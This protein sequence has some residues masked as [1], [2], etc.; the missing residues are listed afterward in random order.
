[1]IKLPMDELRR[2]IQE[3]RYTKLIALEFPDE[4]RFKEAVRLGIAREVPF[5]VPGRHNLIMPPSFES[6]FENMNYKIWPVRSG[7]ELTSEERAELARLRWRGNVVISLKKP[8][9]YG[10]RKDNGDGKT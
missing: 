4:E 5:D 1:M 9:E 7:E 6:V 3:G 2:G 10:S 8:G